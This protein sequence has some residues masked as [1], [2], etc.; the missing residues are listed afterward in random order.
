MPIIILEGIDGSGKSTLAGHI[1]ELSPWPATIVPRG[2]IK[3]SIIEELITPLLNNPDDH[4]LIADRWHLSELIYGP[5]YRGKSEIDAESFAEIESVLKGLGALRVVISPK[6]EDV[7]LRLGLRG[8]DFLK[9]DHQ[10]LVH[11][12]YTG[13]AVEHDYVMTDGS[14]KLTAIRLLGAMAIKQLLS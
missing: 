13:L 1:K 5:L 14:D 11:A 10:Q 9:P 2:P 8:E 4:L 12:A 6:I 7:Q 3:T